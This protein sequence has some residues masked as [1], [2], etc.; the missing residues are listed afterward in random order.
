MRYV[1]QIK[2]YENSYQGQRSRSNVTNFKTLLAF[3]TRHIPT[4]LHQFLTGSFRDFVRTAHRQTDAAKNYTC[5]QHAHRY[6]TVYQRKQPGN[7]Q[8]GRTALPIA[9]LMTDFESD[10]YLS[11][12]VTI[13]LSHLV[14]EIFAC[15]R[16]TDGQRRPLLQLA[17][18]LWRVG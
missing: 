7:T 8:N 6:N 2:K 13:H 16:R 12:L 14:S 1:W 4:K 10:S 18:T 5:L 11:F 15:E 9:N 17:P 3:T